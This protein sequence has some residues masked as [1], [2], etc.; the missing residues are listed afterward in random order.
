MDQVKQSPELTLVEKPAIAW[1]KTLG[2]Q[3]I[4]GKD[5]TLK[6]RTKAPILEDVLKAQL[7]SLNPWLLK[8]NDGATTAFTKLK[9]LINEKATTDNL[10]EQNEKFYNQVLLSS[11]IQVKNHQGKDQTVKF[12]DQVNPR[13]NQFHVVDQFVGKNE[14]GDIFKPDL[15]LFING[16]PLGIIECKK[17]TLPLSDAISQLGGY[18]NTFPSHFCYNMV[19]AAINRDDARYGALETPE[20][21]YFYFKFT[22]EKDK[23]ALEA[24]EKALGRPPNTQEKLL[25]ALFEPSRFV[26]L[27]CFYV[28]FEKEERGVIKKLPRY[29]QWRASE[30]TINRL[31]KDN[32]GGV[33]WHT[34][35]SGKSLTMALLARKLRADVTGFN[36]PSILIITDRTDLDQQIFNT[37]NAVGVNASK[38]TSVTD[39]R[40]K[41]SNDYGTIFTST[42][43]KFQNTTSNFQ[44]KDTTEDEEHNEKAQ[45]DR[46]ITKKDDKGDETYWVV[47]EKNSHFNQVD[48]QG[49]PLTANWVVNKEEK[50]NFSV[51][52]TKDNFIVM[53]D[54]AHRSQYG[55]LAAFMRASLPNATFIA[56]T[57]T[58]LSKATKETLA[59]FGTKDDVY[60]DTYYLSESVADGTTLPII[61]KQ[62]LVE[63]Q[64]DG[65]LTQAFADK[66]GLESE[67][68][69]L[70]LK[71]ALVKQRMNSTA[72]LKQIALYL[73]D[74]FLANVKA[75][76]FKGM[77]VCNGRKQAVAYKDTLDEIMKQRMI[78]NKETFES[79]VVISLGGITANRTDI[80]DVR[81]L[82]NATEGSNIENQAK[83]E[84]IEERVIREV[85]EGVEP[86]CVPT[87]KIT[88]FVNE[89]FK[90]PYGDKTLNKRDEYK[91]NNTGLIIVSDMLLTGWDA[92]IVNTL[93]LDKPL[94]EHTLLQ[95]IAR[96][97]RVKKYKNA[98][99]V[100]D[101]YGVLS[102][103]DEAIK[104][105]GGG[106]TRAHLITEASKLIPALEASTK[107]VLDILPNKIPFNVKG[108]HKEFIKYA[109]SDFDVFSKIDLIH[110]LF[111]A[112]SLFNKDLDMAL[113]DP[114]AIPFKVHF[115]VF[116]EIKMEISKKL[117]ELKPNDKVTIVE[118]V[119]LSELMDGHIDASPLKEYFKGEVNIFDIEYM[120]SLKQLKST[121][122]VSDIL[123]AATRAKINDGQDSGKHEQLYADLDAELLKLLED[124]QN[125]RID[126]AIFL[127]QLELIT[128]KLKESDHQ[129]KR[130]GYINPMHVDVFNYFKEASFSDDQAKLMVDN[131]FSDSTET[132]EGIKDILNTGDVWVKNSQSA[133]KRRLK[134]LLKV[135]SEWKAL[136]AGDH[137]E[138]IIELLKNNVVN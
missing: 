126:S 28:L 41:L 83:L 51:L 101:Y 99:Y 63:W 2:Y 58:P 47:S 116:S 7:L 64:S 67:T 66:F 112:I 103:L 27:V 84:S 100:M 43:Q 52:S 80:S 102:S 129:G 33:I 114:L 93:Y 9:R 98:G 120:T 125:K 45:R 71:K 18:Q 73:V 22:K 91:V 4:Q 76:K 106:L 138:R 68:K 14:H 118:S 135:H 104:E 26:Q 90:L 8:V 89:H 31:K 6:D 5:L 81:A 39:L 30:N 69:Q 19:C 46:R 128:K 95:A 1:L 17:P 50:I 13:N 24:I 86:V 137:A 130:A 79:T 62:G 56:F 42:V 115:L 121:N 29:Q 12:I 23:V 3:H 70:A 15:L 55:F 109:V 117:N 122:E 35:G 85:K 11:N 10:I 96:V 105:F 75:K 133:V 132:K 78:D 16:L 34:Q 110:E 21:F 119:I 53:V 57:G 25:W 94:K 77:L 97:N 131:I 107:K 74:D 65:K 20:Q 40:Q 123:K 48:N 127:E 82:F 111:E 60:I 113:P 88:T 37:F 61:Y 92:P 38:A 49:N 108:S 54:E 36:N 136:I 44:P 87:D 32:K 59:T 134:E 124:E 72:R